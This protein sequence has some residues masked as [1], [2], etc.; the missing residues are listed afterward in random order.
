MF[1]LLCSSL[2]KQYAPLLSDEDQQWVE[3]DAD[4]GGGASEGRQ[5]SATAGGRG[6][7][8]T[9]AVGTASPQRGLSAADIANSGLDTMDPERS[10][11]STRSSSISSINMPLRQS[12]RT[13]SIS[14]VNDSLMAQF[15]ASSVAPLHGGEGGAAAEA[16][17]YA[18]DYQPL[19]TS[20]AAHNPAEVDVKEIRSTCGASASLVDGKENI[21]KAESGSSLGQEPLRQSGGSEVATGVPHAPWKAILTHPASLCLM[22]QAWAY[23]STRAQV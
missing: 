12:T 15:S 8:A 1:C 23:V 2:G 13:T 14:N 22:L 19:Y 7:E 11:A 16:V 3:E 6:P 5:T 18:V 20:S 17:G 21:G 9:G 10:R 4:R